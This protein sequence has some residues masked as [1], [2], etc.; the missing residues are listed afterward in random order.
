MRQS[1]LLTRHGVRNVQDT[2]VLADGSSV[3]M[4]TFSK[5]QLPLF[6]SP[7]N[8]ST[9]GNLSFEGHLMSYNLGSYL[10]KRFKNIKIR[11]EPNLNRVIDTSISIAKGANVS[12][13]DIP[14]GSF[15]SLTNP[16]MY[17]NYPLPSYALDDII[18]IYDKNL[19]EINRISE[20]ITKNLGVKLPTQTTIVIKDGNNVTI[21]GLLEIEFLLAQEPAF[22]IF[23]DLDLDLENTKSMMQSAVITQN[24]KYIPISTQQISSNMA[25]YII[26]KFTTPKDNLEVIVVS[27]W[28]IISLSTL[29]G[30]DFRLSDD[31]PDNFVTANTGILF[32]I[33]NGIVSISSLGYSLE[34]V[35]I[36]TELY[37]LPL[38]NFLKIIKPRINSSYVNLSNIDK[39]TNYRVSA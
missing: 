33:E 39:V 16:Q 28:Q 17:Y 32:E 7:I 9:D 31:Y 8:N 10:K 23:S 20:I 26:D 30:F 13:I 2:V 19:D 38:E 3:K 12:N 14:I 25:Q 1:I 29:M 11:T 24:V 34:K 18:A 22:L 4:Q 35:I 27:D 15:D 6:A 21:T 36:H 37:E 5:K